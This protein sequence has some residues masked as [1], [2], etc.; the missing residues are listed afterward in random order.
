MVNCF[1]NFDLFSEVV[2]SANT[3]QRI[4]ILLTWATYLDWVESNHFSYL[5]KPLNFEFVGDFRHFPRQFYPTKTKRYLKS[6]ENYLDYNFSTD[7]KN[8]ISF[9]VATSLKKEQ[10]FFR[11]A[12]KTKFLTPFGNFAQRPC[13][14]QI[15]VELNTIQISPYDLLPFHPSIHS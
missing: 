9:E 6:D 12:V 11:K 4:N 5:W 1:S 3:I 13:Q 15:T 10:I 7:F 14:R 8:L 2:T